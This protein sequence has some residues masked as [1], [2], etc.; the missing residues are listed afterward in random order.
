MEGSGNHS[1]INQTTLN[2]PAPIALLQDGWGV[3]HRYFAIATTIVPT[4]LSRHRYLAPIVLD[5]AKE[6][7]YDL[8][9]TSFLDKAYG[10][11]RHRLW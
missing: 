2:R 5:M 4:A 3:G 6:S 1:V 8:T 11:S 9:V 10:V 7:V